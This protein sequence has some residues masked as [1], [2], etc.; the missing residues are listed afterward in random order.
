MSCGS[1]LDGCPRTLNQLMP[2]YTA[3]KRNCWYY[4]SCVFHPLGRPRLGRPFVLSLCRF[5]CRGTCPMLAPLVIPCREHR[6]LLAGYVKPVG[7]LLVGQRGVLNDVLRDQGVKP[8]ACVPECLP[9]FLLV[10]EDEHVLAV[11][12]VCYSF[13]DCSP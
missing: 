1:G 11:A 10:R 13:H 8:F 5:R 2:E 6:D 4:T 12:P 7:D 3:R 9:Q